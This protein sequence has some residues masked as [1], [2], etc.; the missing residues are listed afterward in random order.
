MAD[1][2]AVVSTQP[3]PPSPYET[4]TQFRARMDVAYGPGK[5]RD[6]GDW[7]DASRNRQVGGVS[8]SNHMKGT[9]DAPGAHDIVVPGLD[10]GAAAARLPKGYKGLPEGKVGGQGAHVHVEEANPWAVVPTDPWTPVKT[11][12]VAPAAQHYDPRGANMRAQ[13]AASESPL[14]EMWGDVKTAAGRRI[15]EAVRELPGILETGAA[16]GPGGMA[17]GLALGGLNVAVAPVGGAAEAGSHHLNRAVIPNIYQGGNPTMEARDR[18]IGDLAEAAVP[19]PGIGEVNAA[20]KGVS[21]LTREGRATARAARTAEE[22]GALERAGGPRAA[23]APTEGPWQVVRQTPSPRS[24][25]AVAPTAESAG[26]WRVVK[27]EPAPGL[28]QEPARPGR[29][30]AA[31][32]HA[33]RDPGEEIFP[34]SGRRTAPPPAAPQTTVGQVQDTLKATRRIFAASTVGEGREAAA[35]HRRARG[36]FGHAADIDEYTIGRQARLMAQTPEPVQLQTIHAIETGRIDTLPTPELRSAASDIRNVYDS[37]RE[38]IESTLEDDAP[39]FIKDYFAHLWKQTPQEVD[40]AMQPWIGKQGSGRNLK[41][42]SIPTIQEGIEAGLTPGTTNPL[43]ITSH[44]VQ[45]MSRYL[46]TR[47]IQNWMVEG[48]IAKW[49]DEHVAASHDMVP[50]DGI[51]AN[52]PARVVIGSDNK[53]VVNKPA[54]VLAAPPDAARI[55]NRAISSGFNG[56]VA[57]T[58]RGL[59]NAGNMATLALSGYHGVAT[60]MAS[61]ASEMS[62]AFEALSKGRL[63]TAGK[64]ALSA[65][66]APIKLVAKGDKMR[67]QLLGLQVPSSLDQRII[68]S[69]TGSGQRLKVDPVYNVGSRGSGVYSAVKSDVAAALSAGSKNAYGE[70]FRA[71]KNGLVAQEARRALRGATTGTMVDRGRSVIDTAGNVIQSVAGPIFHDYIPALKRGVFHERMA[72][73]FAEHPN[74]TD[75]EARIAGAH[76]GDSVDNRFGEMIQDNIFW[77]RKVKD[78]AQI[79]M[80]SPGWNLGTQREITGGILK[81]IPSMADVLKGKGLSDKTAYVLGLVTTAGLVDSAYQ[82]L[83]TGEAPKDA[84]DVAAP[85]TGGTTSFGKSGEQ[86][87]RA[88]LPGEHKEIFE[89]ALALSRGAP[90]VRSYLEG[91]RNTTF[92]LLDDY[93]RNAD[94][95]GDPVYRPRAADHIQG[96]PSGIDTFLDRIMPI[97][98]KNIRDKKA[99]SNIADPE[100]TAGIRRAPMYLSDPQD[101]GDMMRAIDNRRWK[102]K[103]NKDR[104]QEAA[105]M[106]PP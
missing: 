33:D 30:L 74:A 84:L 93:S 83:K 12:P 36:E 99:G 106:T 23:P 51:L 73:W 6:T 60:T 4:N 98:S 79:T 61:A 52:K 26:P 32:E 55:Y 40:R 64:A 25:A 71:F 91:K 75:E 15:G 82:Y 3:A 89:M 50:L 95:A 67:R 68:D 56:P 80:L 54:Q 49:V 53:V 87:E 35:I 42:R 59:V 31:S 63:L 77:H 90:G 72:D 41:R 70:A 102:T 5:W 103:V 43:E 24:A 1:P 44:Y 16:Q 13:H 76:I 18:T 19:V 39:T 101:Y 96:E 11:E 94:Y 47:Q 69:F 105:R 58:A 97:T 8:N 34:P 38:R 48:G 57:Q 27:Q 104:K 29:S 17:G 7:R 86:P 45:N 100:A 66:I 9:P 62:R 2:W 21:M 85:R 22:A 78:V 10:P 20:R 46:G 37:W 88:I 92:G 65:P 81:A 28:S 14:A